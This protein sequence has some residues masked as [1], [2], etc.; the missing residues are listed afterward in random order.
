LRPRLP[1]DHDPPALGHVSQLARRTTH[2]KGLTRRRHRFPRPVSITW[3]R[4]TIG[5]LLFG[6]V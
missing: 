6:L 2:L 1:R 3:R 5:M 4:A